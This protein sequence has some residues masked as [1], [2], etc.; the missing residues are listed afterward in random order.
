MG[1]L[2]YVGAMEL[3]EPSDK[4]VT[5]IF[6]DENGEYW[7]QDDIDETIADFKKIRLS[8]KLKRPNLE[9]KVSKG[10][11][12]IYSFLT[13]SDDLLFG[14]RDTIELQLLPLVNS[15]ELT[16]YSR[17]LVSSFLKL[18]QKT[19]DLVDDS[20]RDF[21]LL[22]ITDKI[23]K[24][25]AFVDT[26]ETTDDTE[27]LLSAIKTRF[28]S[29]NSINKEIRLEDIAFMNQDKAFFIHFHLNFELIVNKTCLKDDENKK[30]ISDLLMFCT[31]NDKNILQTILYGRTE[32]YEFLLLSEYLVL[33]QRE[34][35]SYLS[36]KVEGF[37]VSPEISILEIGMDV[38][39]EIHTAKT[40]LSID[41]PLKENVDALENSFLSILKANGY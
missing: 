31:K 23:S 18:Y 24:E 20:N 8:R 41:E 22:G 21:E 16:V 11:P 4:F 34:I 6:E 17:L 38:D 14:D 19:L 2:T 32:V 27:K 36:E 15:D 26:V 33:E 3:A 28:N 37:A 12:Y 39:R 25:I 29:F 35:E 30:M 1:P 40:N 10:D 9:I 5:S 13:N 7:A